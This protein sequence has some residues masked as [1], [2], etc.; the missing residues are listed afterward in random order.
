M[1]RMN[2]TQAVFQ[3]ITAWQDGINL[4][5][6]STP[7]AQLLKLMEELGELTEAI[8]KNKDLHEIQSEIGDNLVVLNGIARM[9]GT[10]VNECATV[11][12]DK[13][14]DR[15]GKM[16]NGIFVKEEDL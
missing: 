9:L 15:K 13:I 12:Y 5:N 10:T 11:A 6:D 7:K 8:N 3:R 2:N 14:K 1:K 4:Y 16:I